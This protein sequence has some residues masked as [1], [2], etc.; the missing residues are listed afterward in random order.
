MTKDS[1]NRKSAPSLIWVFTTYFTEGLPYI[2]IRSI[3][4]FFFRASGVS[5][6]AT[7]LTSLYGIAWIVKFLWAPYLD[8][9]GT[10]RR[11][12]LISQGI[13]ACFFILIALLSQFPWAIPPIAILF[14]VA[15]FI[16]STHD[17]AIDGYYLEAL[18]PDGQAQ[19]VGYRVMAY[20]IAM[21]FGS[22]VIVTLGSRAGWLWA[23]GLSAAVLTLLYLF[24]FTFLPSCENEKE[25]IKKLIFHIFTYRF[26]VFLLIVA[27]LFSLSL[28]W[29][30]NK[31]LPFQ[32]GFS[33]L[34]GTLLLFSLILLILLRARLLDHIK[35]RPDSIFAKSFLSFID[36]E[37][38]SAIILFIISVRVGEFM[39]SSMVGPFFIDVGLKEH[40]GWITGAVGLPCSIIGAMS[41][42]WLIARK[43]LKK[44][45]W[46]FLLAQN[47]T[48]LVYMFFA[49]HLLA[50]G[51]K[52]P[53][54]IQTVSQQDII[55]AC[56]VTAFDSWAGGLGTAVLMTFLMG[57]CKEN[58][59]A[60]HYAIGTGLMSVAGVYAGSFSGFLVEWFGYAFLFGIS[61]CFSLPGMAL[62]YFLPWLE[63]KNS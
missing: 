30:K 16:A 43:G 8:S 58:Y 61:F 37:K 45:I 20:R 11:W 3:S 21:M 62:I 35:K 50:H 12:L 42:G 24:H 38:I 1:P 6:E 63:V 52:V 49:S 9:F 27:T 10:K 31:T 40:Y 46:P 14:F 29:L 44:M 23:F 28:S 48:N 2:F 22:G 7:G 18:T 53:D 25:K 26:V 54:G 19:F 13:L 32:L 15:S 41:G 33:D 39:L 34:V 47:L 60:A 36:R 56:G 55:L 51:N 17:T 4:T 5:V 59:K 57:L